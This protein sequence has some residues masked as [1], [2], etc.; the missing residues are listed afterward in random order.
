[1]KG[2]SPPRFFLDNNLSQDLAR[3]LDSLGV[4]AE[5]LRDRFAPD[6][7]D[8][9]WLEYV[10]ENDLF[11]LTRDLNIRSN[12]RLR[13]A[14]KDYRVGA[15]FLGGKERTRLELARQVLSAIY[16]IQ[17]HAANTQKPFA[18]IVRP[19]GG[20]LERLPLDRS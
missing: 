1:M 16:G 18:F 7:E 5:H 19:R 10:G 20:R 2:S 3:A 8:H 13:Q 17:D 9:V 4:P 11:L 14:I 12:P 15:F 6:T